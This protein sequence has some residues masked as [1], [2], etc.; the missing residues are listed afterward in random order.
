MKPNT[1]TLLYVVD[2]LGTF[3]FA[4]EGAMAAIAGSTS[5]A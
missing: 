4:A 1:S 3:V 5:S 2:L